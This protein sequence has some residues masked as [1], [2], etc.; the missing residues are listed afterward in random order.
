MDTDVKFEDLIPINSHQIK[1]V[2]YK[3]HVNLGDYENRSLEMVMELNPYIA[4]SVLEEA[5]NSLIERVELKVKTIQIEELL[6]KEISQL[7]KRAIDER[8]NLAKLQTEIAEVENKLNQLHK[9]E[10]LPEL[11]AQVDF[12]EARQEA[13]KDLF[14]AQR[15]SIYQL[16]GSEFEGTESEINTL[17][18]KND[19]WCDEK[20]D[21]P[22]DYDGQY[23][24]N[25][26]PSDIPM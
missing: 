1:R 23:P 22:G 5:I 3:R 16:L 18:L 14:N 11:I 24:E 19:D 12:L 6:E 13:L 21:G 2:T 8:E 17:I 4:E 7:R 10:N 25:I 15:T 20:P 26:E 9:L